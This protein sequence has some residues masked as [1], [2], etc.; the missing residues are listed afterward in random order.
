[1]PGQM[2]FTLLPPNPDVAVTAWVDGLAVDTDTSESTDGGWAV[3]VPIGASVGISFEKESYANIM[4]LR[5]ASADQFIAVRM[6]LE[7]D[8]EFLWEGVGATYPSD[9]SGFISVDARNGA[10]AP[11]DGVEGTIEPPSGTGARYL[12]MNFAY[13]PALNAT[14]TAGFFVF[15]NV[16]EGLVDLTLSHPTLT[17]R[18]DGDGF[19]AGTPEV[20]RIPVQNDVETAVSVVCE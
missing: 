13:D 19:S 5:V 20:L 3:C 7:Q 15:G 14:S 4:L 10:G 11:L 6:F 12:D 8:V 1:V 18:H 16:D 2:D 9:T 17:C